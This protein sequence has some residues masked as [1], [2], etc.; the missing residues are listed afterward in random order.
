MP[1]LYKSLSLSCGS[2][3]F[4]Y[5]SDDDWRMD[6]MKQFWWWHQKWWLQNISPKAHSHTVALLANSFDISAFRPK[7]IPIW[8]T[9]VGNLSETCLLLSS[10]NISSN[11]ASDIC[12]IFVWWKYSAFRQYLTWKQID[13]VWMAFW[14]MFTF[15]QKFQQQ[16]II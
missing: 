16:L 4:F 9:W 8:H 13:I 1:S 14:V 7:L 2:S 10:M 6:M 12:M 15:V 3:N 5:D 11:S